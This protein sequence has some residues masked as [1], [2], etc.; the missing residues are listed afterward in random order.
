MKQEQILRAAL[1]GPVAAGIAAATQP[2]FAAKGD[3]ESAPAS[4]RRA[5]TIAAL[6]TNAC[7]GQVTKDNHPE[8]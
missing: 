3:N 8:A 4:S 5:R 7:A 6:L 1:A 2:A